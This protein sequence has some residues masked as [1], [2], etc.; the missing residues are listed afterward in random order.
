[1]ATVAPVAVLVAAVATIATMQRD[2]TRKHNLSRS[3]EG[4]NN[5]INV[6]AS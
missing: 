6:N 5:T 4:S 3:K 2:R 1:M